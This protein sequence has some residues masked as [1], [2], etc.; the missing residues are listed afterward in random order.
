MRQLA[1]CEPNCK[2]RDV[3]R[4]KPALGDG[5]QLFGRYQKLR[6]DLPAFARDERCMKGS[7]DLAVHQP[8]RFLELLCRPLLELR[9]GLAPLLAL[10]GDFD[11]L[12]QPDLKID[13]VRPFDEPRPRGGARDRVLLKDDRCAIDGC[14]PAFELRARHQHSR[15]VL[16]RMSEY[17]S[18]RNRSRLWALIGPRVCRR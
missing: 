6:H 4:L 8:A 11:R 13:A 18:Q 2:R 9:R 5:Q 12:P 1:L 15:S 14:L 7:M 16:V 3:A 17:R 10:A